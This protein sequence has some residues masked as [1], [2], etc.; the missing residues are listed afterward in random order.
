MRLTTR[1][2]GFHAG[3]CAAHGRLAP[4]V[5]ER[6]ERVVARLRRSGP[7]RRVGQCLMVARILRLYVAL[8]PWA[9]ATIA[10]PGGLSAERGSNA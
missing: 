6:L 1:S 7:S 2:R 5:G 9:G 4:L 8:G 3:K 10:A